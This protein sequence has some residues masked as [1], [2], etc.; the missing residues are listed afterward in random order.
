MTKLMVLFAVCCSFLMRRVTVADV[1]CPPEDAYTPCYC[2]EYFTTTGQSVIT[3]DCSYAN[4][5]D[6]KA[7]DI[8][9]AF[10]STPDVSP[11]GRLNLFR[12][13]LS[14]IPEQ[15][16]YLNQLIYVH[17]ASNNITTIE[18][19]AFN[20]IGPDNSFRYLTLDSNQVTTIAPGALKGIIF[21][22]KKYFTHLFKYIKAYHFII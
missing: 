14:F 16:E 19:G 6:A 13:Q 22:F 2:T 1:V 17:L 8:L 3:L 9:D 18:S 15:I 20:F 4:L 21:S 10:L 11:L 5:G 7:S 12:C